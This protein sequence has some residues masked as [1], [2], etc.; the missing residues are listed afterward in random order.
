RGGPALQPGLE[1]NGR[2]RGGGTIPLFITIAPLGPGRLCG[3]VRDLS[4]WKQAEAN[5]AEAKQRAEQAAVAKSGLLAKISHEIRAPLSAVIG[6][7]EIMMEERFG[8]LSNA[9]SREYLE[10]I[11]AS[12]GLLVA[13]IGNLLELSMIE[14]GKLELN[15]ASVSLNDLIRQCVTATQPYANRE[16]IIIRSALAPAVPP[17]IADARCV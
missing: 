3:V 15:F 4:P 8:P 12:G 6:F 2:R 14:T 11:H 13:L 1:I 7:S 10:G 5:L 16:R 17:A 9:R